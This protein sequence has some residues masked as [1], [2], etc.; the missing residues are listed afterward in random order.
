MKNDKVFCNI[1]RYW[2]IWMSEESE[3]RNRKKEK[4]YLLY[5]Q[6]EKCSID[7]PTLRFYGGKSYYLT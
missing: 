5:M 6:I 7:I 1:C 4:Q 2:Q 3:E